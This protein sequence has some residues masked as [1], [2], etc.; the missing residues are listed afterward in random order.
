[1]SKNLFFLFFIIFLDTLGIGI[2]IPIVPQLLGEPS[3]IYYLLSPEKG[4]LGFILLGLLVASY[5]LSMFFASPILGA[6]SDKYGRKPILVI[7]ILGTSLSYFVFAFAIFTKNIPLLFISRIVDGATG[8]NISVA[9]AAIADLTPPEDRTKN[10]GMMGSVFGLGFI[11]GP[12]LSGTLSNPSISSFFNAST[13]FIFSGFL[14]FLSA[15]SMIYFFK[16]S[17]KEK[18]KDRK[19]SFFASIQNL[20]KMQKFTHLRFLFVVSFLFTM[21]LTFYT[22]FFNVY[23]TNE[24]NFS[25]VDIGN[26]FAYVGV[27]IIL[28]QFFVVRNMPKRFSETDVLGP[29]YILCGMG[30]LLFLIPDVAWQ[31]FFIVPLAAIP[32]GI[33]HANF[34]SLLTKR[35]DENIRGEV[36]GVQSSISS[37][38]QALP[39]IFAGALAALFN[40]YMPIVLSALL[41]ISAGLFFIFKVQKADIS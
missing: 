26:F 31:L 9:Q 17:I 38:G 13:P 5:P 27:W 37:L 3:S 33:Q 39:P 25:S 41:I 40:S 34:I 16:E 22:S 4:D 19:I 2:L 29:A 11:F 36:L 23:L 18:F 24:F 20:A 12:F 35:A 21:G 7:S 32:H 28:T 10:Y 30:I 6:L 14:A 8:G 15:F 1:M